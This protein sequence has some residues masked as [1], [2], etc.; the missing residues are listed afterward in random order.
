MFATVCWDSSWTIKQE[1]QCNKQ[2]QY[3]TNHKQCDNWITEIRK[4]CSTNKIIS[5]IN[6]NLIPFMEKIKSQTTDCSCLIAQAWKES[7][8]KP[9]PQGTYDQFALN[10]ENLDQI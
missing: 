3:K 5:T 9:D 2:R 10:K 4:Q 7:M 8:V 6:Y 1:K